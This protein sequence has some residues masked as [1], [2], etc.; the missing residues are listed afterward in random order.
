MTTA[1]QFTLNTGERI[2]PDSCNARRQRPQISNPQIDQLVQRFETWLEQ[3][4]NQKIRLAYNIAGKVHQNDTRIDPP[5]T[6]YIAHPTSVA[7]WIIEKARIE[8]PELIISALLH[9]CLEDHPEAFSLQNVR[10]TFG[11]KVANTIQALTNPTKLKT[12]TDPDIKR[13]T[14]IQHVTDAIK[15]DD[16]LVVKLADFFKNARKVKYL[17][18]SHPKKAVSMA[19]KYQALVPH[20]AAQIPNS[21]YSRNLS[22]SLNE[23]T[24][25][26]QELTDLAIELSGTSEASY[27]NG[28]NG[29]IKTMGIDGINPTES[30]TG[31]SAKDRKAPSAQVPVN[32]VGSTQ[33]YNDLMAIDQEKLTLAIRNAFAIAITK[34]QETMTQDSVIVN[35]PVAN[36]PEE[37]TIELKKSLDGSEI[38]VDAVIYSKSKQSN[39]SLLLAMA[40]PQEIDSILQN[41]NTVSK[42]KDFIFSAITKLRQNFK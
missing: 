19:Q 2:M 4:A 26:T 11:H 7:L 14:Y 6:P 13:T 38:L 31:N 32:E 42:F 17:K 15:D 18:D 20:F 16:V 23:L 27:Q 36:I 12:I 5:G 34:K 29:I 22:W 28:A 33:G 25:L 10:K 21:R 3:Q 30:T 39:S 37:I 9:D 24:K 35:V 8:S 1:L 41:D 40:H